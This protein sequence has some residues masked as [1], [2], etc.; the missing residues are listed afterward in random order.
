L[1]RDFE[2]LGEVSLAPI[3]LGAEHAQ[4]VLHWYLHP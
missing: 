1:A 4:A 2:A 3:A